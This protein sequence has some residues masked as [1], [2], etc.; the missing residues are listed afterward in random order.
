MRL[1]TIQTLKVLAVLSSKD[2]VYGL[3]V[4]RLARIESGTAY[5]ILKRLEADGWVKGEW[6]NINEFEAQ[7]PRRRYFS[8]TGLGRERADEILAVV[9]GAL[10]GGQELD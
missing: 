9:R 10:G 5:P 8:L 3:E 7:R 1:P 6:E 4:M 2:Q